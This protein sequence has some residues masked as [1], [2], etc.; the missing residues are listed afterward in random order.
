MVLMVHYYLRL[1]NQGLLKEEMKARAPALWGEAKSWTE[2][3]FWLSNARPV[4]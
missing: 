2:L 1:T 3:L 4:L